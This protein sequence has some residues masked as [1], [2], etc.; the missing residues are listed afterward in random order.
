MQ[1]TK[2]CM[3]NLIIKGLIIC[4][5]PLLGPPGCCRFEISCSDYALMQLDDAPFFKAIP[6]IIKRVL[7]C[8][9]FW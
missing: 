9:P 3:V 5:R 6:A 2:N 7:S 8:N 4:I 1:L